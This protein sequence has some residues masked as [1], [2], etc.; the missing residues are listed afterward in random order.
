MYKWTVRPNWRNALNNFNP[1]GKFVSN[2]YGKSYS[3]HLLEGLTG[4][5]QIIK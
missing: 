3:K 1:F 2:Y 4:L 5:F